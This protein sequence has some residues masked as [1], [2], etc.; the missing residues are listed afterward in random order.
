MCDAF[1][2]IITVIGAM[3]VGLPL[4]VTAIQILWINVVSDGFPHLALTVDPHRLDIMSTPPRK[5][6]EHIINNWMR[7]LIVLVSLS[8][9]LIALVVFIYTYLNTSDL[10]LARSLTFATLGAN[11]L[12]YVFSVR[13]LKK[14]FWKENP[15]KNKWLN[16]SV[17]AGVLF[18]LLPF[19]MVSL[20][21]FF[22][23]K[24]LSLL[25]WVSVF[26]AAILMFFIIETSKIIFR[27]RVE[28]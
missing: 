26:F 13:T 16:I 18:Q 1:G 2:E 28:K 17:V 7:T 5:P 14:P 4:P 27:L 25:Q 15:F 3:L 9:G 11:S 10:V 6:D 19:T 23:L 24:P 20:R 12:V 21:N 22:D 8:A